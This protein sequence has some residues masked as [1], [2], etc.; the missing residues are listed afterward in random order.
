MENLKTIAVI[1]AADKRNFDVLR[2]LSERY[3]LLLFDKNPKALSDIYD[4]LLANNPNINIEKMSCATDASWE[5][6]II[7]L[8]GFCIND[9]EIVRKVKKVATAKIIIIMENDDEFTKSINSQVSFDLIFPHSKIVEII[10]LNADESA[11]KE[12]LLEGHDSYA[13][14]RVSNILERMGFNTYVSQLN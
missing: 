5:A 9:E 14:D 4:S 1:G 10:N 8:S 12:F 7:I 11:D 3:Q 2:E 6:D 13:L